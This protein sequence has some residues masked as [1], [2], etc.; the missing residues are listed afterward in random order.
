MPI[1]RRRRSLADTTFFERREQRNS[2]FMLV[3]ITSEQG[4]KFGQAS[5]RDLSAN[6][7]LLHLTT[8]QALPE[9]VLLYFPTERMKRAV[10]VRWQDQSLIGVEF[11]DPIDLPERMRSQKN[12]LDVVTSHFERAGFRGQHGEQRHLL[13]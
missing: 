6:G 8:S 5:L 7:A 2:T 11:D 9:K 12:R 4:S 10:R 1:F 13:D 3:D